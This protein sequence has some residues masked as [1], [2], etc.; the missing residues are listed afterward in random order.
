MGIVEIGFGVRG[1]GVSE[2][3]GGSVGGFAMVVFAG[4]G[5]VVSG[6]EVLGFGVEVGRLE[7]SG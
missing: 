2:F 3:V 4:G 6:L 1:L 5:C 7:A